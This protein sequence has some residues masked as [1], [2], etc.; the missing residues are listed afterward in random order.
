MKGVSCVKR[1][2]WNP[3]VQSLPQTHWTIQDWLF[4]IVV[5]PQRLLTVAVIANT[6]ALKTS[7]S[8]SQ[9]TTVLKNTGYLITSVAHQLQFFLI[10]LACTVLLLVCFPVVFCTSLTQ[11]TFNALWISALLKEFSLIPAK[12]TL[13]QLFIHP[14]L[15][16]C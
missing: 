15:L 13:L 2:A 8:S 3:G 1:L 11:C 7:L 16:Y 6:E 9:D 4:K 5:Y 12:F 10:L 14:S